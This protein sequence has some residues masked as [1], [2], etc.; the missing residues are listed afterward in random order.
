MKGS[1]EEGSYGQR[2]KGPRSG[3]VPKGEEESRGMGAW[4]S[5]AE[6]RLMMTPLGPR[7]SAGVGRG[8]ALLSHWPRPH[9]S[10]SAVCQCCWSLAWACLSDRSHL[11]LSWSP[12]TCFTDCPIPGT[13]VQSPMSSLQKPTSRSHGGPGDLPHS[14]LPFFSVTAFCFYFCVGPWYTISLG[15]H[16]DEAFYNLRRSSLESFRSQAGGSPNAK[17][18]VCFKA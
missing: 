1:G 4:P 5:Q 7:S 2:H 3:V 10:H 18:R 16:K 15:P 14:G 8:Y 11:V 9:S 12:R 13:Q 6:M 17:F